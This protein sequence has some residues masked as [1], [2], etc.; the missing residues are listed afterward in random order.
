V[1]SRADQTRPLLDVFIIPPN[2]ALDIE[3]KILELGSQQP[4]S[5]SRPLRACLRGTLASR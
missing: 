3:Y 1:D 5:Q 4:I 2:Q